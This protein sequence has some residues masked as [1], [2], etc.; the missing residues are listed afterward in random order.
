VRETVV[1][2]RRGK[3]M[4]LDA[5]D[6]DTASAGSFF[7]NPI[8]DGAALARLRER[9]AAAL[10]EQAS[11]PVFPEP[12]GRAKV[13]AAWLIERGGFPKGHALGPVA[14][15]SKHALALTNRGG[16]TTNDLLALARAIRDG[17]RSKFGV[18][19]ENEPVFVGVAL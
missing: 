2:L 5:A 15:S 8:L 1:A 14:I 12:D 13:S 11:L 10:G 6:S 3:G 16:A 17:V 7:T 9:V 19:L 18:T 4:V